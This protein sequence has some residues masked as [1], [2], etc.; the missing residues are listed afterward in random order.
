MP[1]WNNRGTWL[2]TIVLEDGT[3]CYGKFKSGWYPSDGFNAVY[4][5]WDNAISENRMPNKRK[6]FSFDIDGDPETAVWHVVS[7][8][9]EPV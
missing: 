3:R 6:G 7:A 2:V 9:M 8:T 4:Q 1:G 5:R